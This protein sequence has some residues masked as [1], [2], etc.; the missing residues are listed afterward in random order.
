MPTVC[1]SGSIPRRRPSSASWVRRRVNWCNPA[2]RRCWILT[3]YSTHLQLALARKT[4]FQEKVEVRR[5]QAPFSKQP[6]ENLGRFDVLAPAL[7][8]VCRSGFRARVCR[9]GKFA[10]RLPRF[11]SRFC[12]EDFQPRK[13]SLGV[14]AVCVRRVDCVALRAA[15]H[16]APLNAQF[17]GVCAVLRG[18]KE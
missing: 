11:P 17:S 16:L 4:I 6:V 5:L 2:E 14:Y 8:H 7:R 13:I 3:D 9:R 1:P 12:K 18:S 15:T 10:G